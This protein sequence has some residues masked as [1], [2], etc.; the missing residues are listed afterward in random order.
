MVHHIYK[1]PTFTDELTK[2]MELGDPLSAGD[3]SAITDI[4]FESI[5]P[6]SLQV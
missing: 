3:E 1:L 6:I 4:L 5:K 2:K